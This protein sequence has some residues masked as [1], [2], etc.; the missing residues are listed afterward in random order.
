MIY[1]G[2]IIG[3]LLFNLGFTIRNNREIASMKR[4]LHHMQRQFDSLAVDFKEHIKA[5]S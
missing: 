4:D 2:F 3:L 5:Y 1:E